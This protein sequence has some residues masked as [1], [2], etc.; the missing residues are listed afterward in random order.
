MAT[1]RQNLKAKRR[2]DGIVVGSLDHQILLALRPGSV[3]SEQVYARFHS[4][5]QVM[6]KLKRAG[7]IETPPNGQKGKPVR[8]SD[9]GRALVDPDGPLAR[10][11][12]LIDYLPSLA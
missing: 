12:S 3:T 6:C 2:Q 7:L 4:P 11:N 8:L 10:R 1:P 9:A 5:S